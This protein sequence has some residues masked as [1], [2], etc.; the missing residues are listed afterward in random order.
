MS[1]KNFAA[2]FTCAADPGPFSDT[3]SPSD[4][5][6]FCAAVTDSHTIYLQDCALTGGEILDL[7]NAVND[8]PRDAFVNKTS[9]G[10]ILFVEI[11]KDLVAHE[12]I[13][14]G[15]RSKAERS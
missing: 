7:L 12:E 10:P 4:V 6:I 11:E 2:E 9:S 8:L 14:G 3:A 1:V 15:G 5:V 13:Y